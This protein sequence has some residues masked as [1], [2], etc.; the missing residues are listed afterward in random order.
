[1]ILR[2]SLDRSERV[3]DI[4]RKFSNKTRIQ[5]EFWGSMME[6]GLLFRV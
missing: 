1:M 6:V 2:C 3:F 5:M 4:I